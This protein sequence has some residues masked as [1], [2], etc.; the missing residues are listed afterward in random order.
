MMMEQNTNY[1]YKLKYNSTP[2]RICASI[3]MLMRARRM[4]LRIIEYTKRIL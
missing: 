3:A 4:R 1:D 2:A